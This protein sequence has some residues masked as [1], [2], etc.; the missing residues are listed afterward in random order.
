MGLDLF[1]TIS[2]IQ[3]LS[4][5]SKIMIKIKQEIMNMKKMFLILGMVVVGYSVNAQNDQEDQDV[6]DN[7]EM[8]QDRSNQQMDQNKQM[9]QGKQQNNI[10][11]EVSSALKE[12]YPY[13]KSSEVEWNKEGSNYEAQFMNKGIKYEVVIEESGNWV[14]TETE[15][16][17]SELPDKVKEGLKNSEYNNW[18][19]KEVEKRES[20][21][22]KT[23]YI[24]EV[25]K[26]QQDFDV[27]FDQNGKILK[28]VK[29]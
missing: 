20:P 25:D 12:K 29:G 27:Y 22:A 6:Q 18:D 19:V 15:M 8:Q 11:T 7:Q 2:I 3:K 28:K 5:R 26:G 24:I 23:Q 1:P 13:V 17:K 9:E 16:S 14:A 10:P 21:E 4:K